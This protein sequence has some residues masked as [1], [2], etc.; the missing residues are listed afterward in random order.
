MFRATR[1]LGPGLRAAATLAMVLCCLAVTDASGRAVAGVTRGGQQE[2]AGSNTLAGD[3]LGRA[4]ALSGDG[5]TAL[6]GAPG[7]DSGAGA[8]YVFTRS[9]TSWVQEQELTAADAA[10][11]D[12]FGGS[13]ALSSDGSTALIGADARASATGAAYV[14]VRS[15]TTWTQQQELA[16]PDG[17]PGDRLGGSVALSGDGSTALIGADA[18]GGGAGAAYVFSRSDT[19]LGPAADTDGIRRGRRRRHPNRRPRHRST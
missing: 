13:V 11:G 4:V 10:P 16:A 7:R 12:R 2:L 17:A 1:A 3:D 18:G 8:V 5:Q 14:F 6:V 9:G 15:V 19:D